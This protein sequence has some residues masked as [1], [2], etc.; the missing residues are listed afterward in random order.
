MNSTL[1][2]GFTRFAPVHKASI[3]RTYN[4]DSNVPH[5]PF[6]HWRARCTRGR[7]RATEGKD[8][9]GEGGRGVCYPEAAGDHGAGVSARVRALV[10]QD[11]R[12]DRWN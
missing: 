9:G 1:M 2:K 10:E 6:P 12:R 11:K 8:R 3:E 4:V 7:D 5:R